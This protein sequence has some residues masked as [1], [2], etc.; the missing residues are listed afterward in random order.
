M[1]I[2]MVNATNFGS[3]GE[4]MLGIAEAARERGHTVFTAVPDSRDNRRRG[5]VEG[6]MLIG[7]RISRNL[8]RLSAKY[9]AMDGRLSRIATR[10]LIREIEHRGIELVHLHNLHGSYLNLG[11][12]LGHLKRRG[13]RTVMTLHDCWT[14]TGHC[15][16][17]DFQGCDKWKSGCHSCP[18]HREYPECVLDDSRRNYK[19]KRACFTEHPD[20]EIVTPSAWL[21]SLV[22]ESYL[23]KYPTRVIY[24]GIDLDVFKPTESD[25]R[26]RL[27]IGERKMLLGVAFSW[28]GRK[29]LDAFLELRRRLGDEYAIVLVGD[30][31]AATHEGIISIPR[32]HDRRELAELYTAADLFVNPTKEDNFPTVNLEAL[33]SG[34]PVLTYKTGGS[35]E[36]VDPS[37]GSVVQRDD[38]SALLSEVIRITGE[39]PFSPADCIAR[40][41]G[42]DR[43]ARF[44][45]YVDLYEKK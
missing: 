19:Y 13:I 31:G 5:E 30:M 14:F 27:G 22:A 17:F 9:L 8:H 23:A 34:T 39:K 10:R 45:E 2:L 21:A 7:G 20:L 37:C 33:A 15:P 16:H 40:A 35:P 3:T 36:S 25:I 24:N 12:L 11:M 1:N 41:R 4:I 44:A 32:T 6:Q 29:G 28:E 38:I 42:F 43:G 18:L 26:D